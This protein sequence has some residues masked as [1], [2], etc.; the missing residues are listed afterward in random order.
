MNMLSKEAYEAIES[1]VIAGTIKVKEEPTYEV[2][3]D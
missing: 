3:D 1:I 2:Q